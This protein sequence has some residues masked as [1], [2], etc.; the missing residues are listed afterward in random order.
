MVKVKYQNSD[1]YFFGTP[2]CTT[3]EHE[4]YHFL[5]G[6]K[7]ESALE[8]IRLELLPLP[9]SHYIFWAVYL[10]NVFVFVCLPFLFVDLLLREICPSHTR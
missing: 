9:D 7:L 5:P 4:V 1:F 6:Q 8:P 3:L 10:C 2:Y